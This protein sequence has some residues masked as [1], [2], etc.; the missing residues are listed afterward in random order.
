MS[1]MFSLFF[2]GDYWCCL[3][4]KILYTLHRDYYGLYVE[5]INPLLL[6]GKKN[7]KCILF[8]FG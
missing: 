2:S 6:H 7:L 8:D 5:I 4:N 3:A 1:F